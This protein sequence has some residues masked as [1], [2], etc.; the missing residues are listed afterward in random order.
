MLMLRD[1]FTERDASVVKQV[2]RYTMNVLHAAV[3]VESERRLKLQTEVWSDVNVSA[4]WL[5][6]KYPSRQY[7]ISPN[8]LPNFK[9]S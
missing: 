8:Q 1:Q 5:K 4:G 6:V 9:N 2:F 7:A 3:A